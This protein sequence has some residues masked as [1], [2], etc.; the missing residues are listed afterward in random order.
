MSDFRQNLRGIAAIVT[1]SFFFIANDALIKLASEHHLPNGEII[2]LRGLAS[3]VLVAAILLASGGLRNWRRVLTRGVF[4]R[5]AGEIGGT[6]TYLNALFHLP[7]ANA[8]T[9]MQAVPLSA[10]AAAALF[11]GERVGPRRWAAI[12]VGFV[13]V[14][15]V[16]RPGVGGFD[17]YALWALAAVVFVTLRDLSTRGIDATVPTL[18]ITGFACLAL[19]ITGALLGLTEDWIMP[20]PAAIAQVLGAAAALIVGF[21]AIIIAMRTGDL[22]VV[23]PFRYILVVWATL[24]GIFVWQ[25]VPDAL[26]FTGM[27]VI[28]AAGIYTLYRERK[29]HLDLKRAPATAAV[30]D[31]GAPQP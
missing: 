16:L 21:S 31:S 7:I 15:I 12:G 8:T 3:T 23:A 28:V 4:L 30:A 22:S 1:S 2:F 10:T 18:L 17:A 20:P 25:Q 13:G 19:T 6:V 5:T 29:L 11:L 27:G 24:W 26:T 9:I 14:L